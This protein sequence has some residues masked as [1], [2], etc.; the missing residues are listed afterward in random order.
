[1]KIIITYI[2]I[3]PMYSNV[4]CYHWVYHTSCCDHHR[5][6]LLFC[7]VRV[8]HLFLGLLGLEDF[9]S[10]VIIEDKYCV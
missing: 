1:M 6:R 7:S 5:H 2:Y 3:Y 9:W 10:T 4:T 8:F